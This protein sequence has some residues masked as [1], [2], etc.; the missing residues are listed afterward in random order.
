MPIVEFEVFRDY[1]GVG[2]TDP[3]V[4]DASRLFDAIAAEIKRLTRRDF[5]GDEGG[6]YNE[7]IR[8]DGASEFTLPHVP[9]EAVTS[10][11]RVYYDG[12][13][14]DVYETTL[15]RLESAARG[16]VSLRP[17][18]VSWP[19]DHDYHDHRGPELVRVLWT[20]T[21]EIPAALPVAFLEW[22]KDRWDAR[23]QSGALA[24]YTTG[25]DSETYFAMLAGRPPRS[26]ML[27]I[28]GARHATG[29]GK[30]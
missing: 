12:T 28:L 27:A 14:D 30:I 11:N 10:I 15:W 13:E 21:G 6:S 16:R 26:A 20:T 9:V 3:E 25:Q 5:E 8:L 1:L 29:G 22:G 19:H 2:A 4:D 7:V 18:G 23:E 17:C 24:A